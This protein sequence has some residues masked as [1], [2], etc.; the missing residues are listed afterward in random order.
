MNHSGCCPKEMQS[1]EESESPFDLMRGVIRRPIGTD[2][3]R[4]KE[5]MAAWRSKEI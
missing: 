4:D 5:I 1:K 2:P 3:E